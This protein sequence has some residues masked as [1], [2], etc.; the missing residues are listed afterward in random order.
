MGAYFDYGMIWLVG[1]FLTFL[2]FTMSMRPYTLEQNILVIIIGV[3]WPAT[4]P[5]MVI[6]KRFR[7]YMIRKIN[8]S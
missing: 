3:A 8:G 4:V 2:A 7:S 1:I 6:S 5:M